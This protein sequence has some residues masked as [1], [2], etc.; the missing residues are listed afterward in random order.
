MTDY[1]INFKSSETLIKIKIHTILYFYFNKYSFA[2]TFKQ[3]TNSQ[4]NSNPAFLLNR[5][6]RL[7]IF[8]FTS[9]LI[10]KEPTIQTQ[11][12]YTL[13]LLGMASV[14]CVVAVFL[15]LS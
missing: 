9:V 2:Q 11:I 6:L 8:F 13:N 7:G 5:V 14:F 10:L 3:R 12:L 1:L 4:Q 15:I